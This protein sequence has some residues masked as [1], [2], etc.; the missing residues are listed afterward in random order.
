MAW[1]RFQPTSPLGSRHPLAAWHSSGCTLG[2]AGRG[3]PM[4]VASSK[5]AHSGTH[6]WV[7]GVN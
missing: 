4:R 1:P 2:T 6:G 3:I 7:Q 5:L